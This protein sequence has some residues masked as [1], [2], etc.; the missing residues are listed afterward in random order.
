MPL[1]MAPAEHEDVSGMIWFLSYAE[2]ALIIAAIATAIGWVIMRG[3]V[4][5]HSLN[6]F[7]ANGVSMLIGG[8]ISL[9]HSAL[10]EDWAPL[11]VND[12]KWFIIWT[13]VLILNS[14]IIAYNLHAFL[15]KVYNLY[16]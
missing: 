7:V 4:K 8:M 9:G 14:N 3:L 5:K 2:L 12:Y 10:V 6:I 15:C 11:P 13:F 16:G 1:L